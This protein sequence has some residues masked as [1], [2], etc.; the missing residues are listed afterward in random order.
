MEEIRERSRNGKARVRV[1]NVLN[2]LVLRRTPS[3]RFSHV[4]GRP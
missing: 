2:V 1:R 3:R 4:L